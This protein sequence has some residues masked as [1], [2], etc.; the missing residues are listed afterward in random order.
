MS[1]KITFLLSATVLLA[2]L[3]PVPVDAQPSN[4]VAVATSIDRAPKIDGRLDDAVWARAIAIDD[5]TQQSPKTGDAPTEQTQVYLLY[6]HDA[7]YVG[8][9]DRIR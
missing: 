5:F 7:L 4:K 1:C 3:P 2:T 9:D 8:A 6:D